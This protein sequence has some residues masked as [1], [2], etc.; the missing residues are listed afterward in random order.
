MKL[1]SKSTLGWLFIFSIL[2]TSCNFS[3]IDNSQLATDS[4]MVWCLAQASYV[5]AG[6]TLV[7]S[8]WENVSF[9]DTKEKFSGSEAIKAKEIYRTL[10]QS[11]KIYDFKEAE[12]NPNSI[13][14]FYWKLGV[15]L[16]TSSFLTKD[17][18]FDN[19]ISNKV[20]NT[21]VLRYINYS[22]YIFDHWEDIKKDYE[23][24]LNNFDKES[25]K[26]YEANYVNSYSICK[27]WFSANNA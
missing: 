15:Q 25:I 14:N 11:I 13:N 18:Y 19:L 4:E 24:A 3:N 5:R 2:F 22:K 8:N 6:S 9:S 10:F 1:L 23:L 17:K 20:E 27:I 21:E 12:D 7:A 16:Y 26:I